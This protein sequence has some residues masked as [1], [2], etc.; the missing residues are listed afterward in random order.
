MPT[1]ATIPFTIAP[2]VHN[3]A[4]GAINP[5]SITYSGR[6]IVHIQQWGCYIINADTG[7]FEWLSPVG[8]FD[9]LF[10]QPKLAITGDCWQSGVSLAVNPTTEKWIVIVGAPACPVTY[11]LSYPFLGQRAGSIQV[12]RMD[13][14]V[15]PRLSYIGEIRANKV[16][17]VNTSPVVVGDTAYFKQL[18]GTLYT[19]VDLN[20]LTVTAEDLGSAPGPSYQT[21]IDGY[22]YTLAPVVPNPPPFPFPGPSSFL[23]I[24]SDQPLPPPPGGGPITFTVQVAP[25]P[26]PI[27]TFVQT[28]PGSGYTTA[29]AVV[30]GGGGSGAT[31]G[32]VIG[33]GGALALTLTNPG[34]GYVTI[35]T[36]VI[37]G[38]GVGAAA[39]VTLPVPVQSVEYIVS[40][41]DTGSPPATIGIVSSP[42]YSL[43]WTP[44][45][46]GRLKV[47]ARLERGVNTFSDF[48]FIKITTNVITGAAVL[49]GVEA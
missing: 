35:P 22:T 12:C 7:V 5:T 15:F 40:N 6:W 31:V 36:I 37:T 46:I 41:V 9:A 26:A 28:S 48:I 45:Q 27:A 39:H 19:E 8:K 13:G 11:P 32:V 38:D 3:M 18:D 24:R 47:E 14:V 29:T 2:K 21:D 43:A 20:S 1:L 30:H 49:T 33:G 23:A 16:G 25:V 42:P 44:D 17:R 34:T 4:W 10:Q